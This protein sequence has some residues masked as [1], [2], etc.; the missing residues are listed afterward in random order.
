M[1]LPHATV[2]ALVLAVLLAPAAADARRRVF[3]CGSVRYEAQELGSYQRDD[4]PAAGGWTKASGQLR[5]STLGTWGVCLECSG[6]IPGAPAWGCAG[7]GRGTLSHS[8]L[9][10]SSHDHANASESCKDRAVRPGNRTESEA[11]EQDGPLPPEARGSVS[12][13]V[14]EGAYSLM[15]NLEEA[16]SVTR[17]AHERTTHTNRCSPSPPPEETDAQVELPLSVIFASEPKPWPGGGALEDSAA[18]EEE[19]EGRTFCPGPSTPGACS[20]EATTTLSW[21]LVRKESDC[22]ARVTRASGEATLGGV[23]VPGEGEVPLGGS[24]AVLTGRHARLELRLP[25]DQKAIYRFGADTSVRLPAD[26]CASSGTKDM[27]TGLLTGSLFVWLGGAIGSSPKFEISTGTAVT[28]S[29]GSLDR[30]MQLLFPWARAAPSSAEPAGPTGEGDDAPAPEA[31]M[32][33]AGWP[34]GGSAVYLWSGP[35]GAVGVRLFR[36]QA[37]IEDPAGKGTVTLSAGQVFRGPAVARKRPVVVT[38][39]R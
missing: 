11:R 7:A 8:Y 20:H 18:V 36:G 2:A 35:G 21:R 28:G 34:A 16:V 32:V 1:R 12:M 26:P 25:G 10:T 9:R 14:A 39:T 23:P 3:Y 13:T 22:T 27:T 17:V 30:L 5:R 15:L 31:A 24:D 29:R 19:P 33:P 6:A 38:V 37:H 4:R